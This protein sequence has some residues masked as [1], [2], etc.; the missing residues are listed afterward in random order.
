M[1]FASSFFEVKSDQIIH[2][3]VGSE[4]T[5][6]NLS[7]GHYY[8]LAN[9]GGEVWALIIS[10][11]GFSEILSILESSFSKD[12]ETLKS[13][14]SQFISSLLNEDILMKVENN[15]TSPPSIWGKFDF[16]EY[17]KPHLE[18]FT[19]I[20]ELLLLDPIHDVDETGWPNTIQPEN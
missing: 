6:V 8:N 11:Q 19:D 4:V 9:L 5:I 3:S 12:K 20:E 13:D 7:N 1:S 2:E 17:E 16:L 18:V 14:L 10:G 15:L